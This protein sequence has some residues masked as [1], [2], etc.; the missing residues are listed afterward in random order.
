[1]KKSFL[2]SLVILSVASLGVAQPTLTIQADK[3]VK[4]SSPTLYGLMTEEINHSYDGGLYAELIQ[5]RAF[6]D[7]PRSPVNWS[8]VPAE[9]AATMTLDTNE[10]FNGRTSLRLG[11]TSAS[12]SQPAGI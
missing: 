12:Q 3:I 5:N 10:L 11:V 9:A 2:V 4:Q 6:Q 8:I 7:N 1:M